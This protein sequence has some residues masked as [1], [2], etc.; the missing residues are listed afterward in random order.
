MSGAELL[1]ALN[2]VEQDHQIVLNIIQALK[3]AIACLLRPGDVD[4]H[5]VLSRLKDINAYLETRFTAHML[6]EETTLFPLLEQF[7]PEGAEL[8]A[9]LRLEHEEIR[10]KRENFGACLAVAFDVEES[11]PRAVLRDILIDGWELWDLLDKHT[12]LETHA[13]QE[14]LARAFR[15]ETASSALT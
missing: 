1:A 14:C 5:Q 11:L 6:E 7:K 10:R 4:P 15:D 12:Y 3:D 8:A 13:V 2:T 9:R